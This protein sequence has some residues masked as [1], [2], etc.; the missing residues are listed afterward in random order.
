MNQNKSRI[1][2]VDMKITVEFSR[3]LG[4]FTKVYV[5]YVLRKSLISRGLLC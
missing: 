4:I 3:I 5:L 1:I 2:M